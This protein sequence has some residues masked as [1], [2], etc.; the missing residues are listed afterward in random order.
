MAVNARRRGESEG[1][2]KSDISLGHVR[3]PVEKKIEGKID[4]SKKEGSVTRTHGLLSYA[5]TPN[6]SRR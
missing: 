2:P 4:P 6:R 3:L 5:S 1:N